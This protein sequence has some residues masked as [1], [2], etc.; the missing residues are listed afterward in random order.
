MDD[1]RRV[2]LLIGSP[3]GGLRGVVPDI[4]A[5]RSRLV[6][7]GFECRMCIGD[8]ATRAKILKELRSLATGHWTNDDAIVV[9]Y[10]GHGGRCLLV[11]KGGRKHDPA[12]NYL[13]PMDHDKATNFRGIADFE[14]ALLFHD[15]SKKTHNITVILDCCHASTMVRGSQ[16]RDLFRSAPIF[17]PRP[18]ERVRR[19]EGQPHYVMPADLETA[20]DQFQARKDDLHVDSNPYV[21]RLVATESGS[22]AFEFDIDG[23]CGG[24]LT[25][26]LCA[27]L[28]EEDQVRA[29][30]AK[31]ERP[32][33]S[34][35]RIVGRVRER[36]FVLRDSTTQR[37][38]IEGPLQRLVFSLETESDVVDRSTLV[39]RADGTT[40]LKAGRLHG[41]QLKDNF[42]VLGTGDGAIAEANVVE[43]FAD[44][45]RVELRTHSSVRPPV[46]RNDPGFPPRGSVVKLAPHLRRE[47]VWVDDAIPRRKELCWLLANQ[48]R[49]RLVNVVDEATFRI[50]AKNRHLI[51]HGPTWYRRRPRSVDSQLAEL[52]DDLDN[53]AR[54]LILNEQLASPPGLS[55]RVRWSATMFV[56]L[57]EEDEY[58]SLSA[59][60]QLPVGT[61]AYVEI[62][63]YNRASPRLYINVLDRGV[64]GRVSLLNPSQPAGVPLHAPEGEGS[65]GARVPGRGSTLKL[66]WPDDVPEDAPLQEMFIV[67]ASQRPLDLRSTLSVPAEMRRSGHQETLS[68]EER[69]TREAKPEPESPTTN[70][71]QPGAALGTELHWSKEFIAFSLIP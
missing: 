26:E 48:T 6:R 28:D 50:E 44:H 62:E 31:D 65:N 25:R 9:Y 43:L 69:E 58:R 40:W 60:D 5:M 15:L 35:S 55:S 13:V 11:T 16:R 63:S 56:K 10:S 42:R 30:L 67:V 49:L 1:G 34:W 59:N 17:E 57:P 14:L 46:G 39:Y 2:A 64:S 20:Y 47:T 19:W 32:H 52:A 61:R 8:A 53:V 70:D 33:T 12:R 45:A 22:P 23:I 21:V 37:P 18:Q 38:E 66:I 71:S 24:Y 4:R 7:R 54:G 27:A 51:V 68:K 29:S 36:I 41:L 3:K